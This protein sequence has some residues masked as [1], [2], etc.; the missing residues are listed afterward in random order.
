MK[1]GKY[2]S[3]VLEIVLLV[4]VVVLAAVAGDRLQ[5]LLDHLQD[6]RVGKQTVVVARPEDFLSS[7]LTAHL[8]DFEVG[9]AD[10]LHYLLLY[11]LG[12]AFLL[13]GIGPAG[14]QNEGIRHCVVLHS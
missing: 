6:L 11:T 7:W 13:G 10:L 12:Y 9:C 2:R 3:V 14:L 5:V 8:D 4:A 1:T